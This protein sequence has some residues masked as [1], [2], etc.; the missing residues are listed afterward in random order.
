MTWQQLRDLDC[1][2][3]R[4]L[5]DGWKSYVDAM[6]DQTERLRTDVVD[7]HLAVEHYESDTAARVREQIGLTADRY[8]DDLS[9]YASTRIA[10]TL[11]E[12]ADAFEAEQGEIKELVPL[13]A[14]HDFEIEGDPA[15]YD[16]NL[17]G[18]LHRAIL[19][20]D[21]PQWLCDMVGI[22][23]PAGAFDL[24]RLKVLFNGV[25]LYGTAIGLAGQYQDWL[26][27][28]MSRT[29][30]ADDEAAAALTEMREHPTELPPRLGAAYDELV[31]DYREAVSEEVAAEAKAIAEGTSGM[32]PEQVNQW[33]DHLSDSERD[34]LVEDHPGWVG[35]VD[36]IPTGPRDTANRSLLDRE[37]DGLDA[38]IAD[39]ER[40]LAGTDPESDE[41]ETLTEAV[42]G[43]KD[44]RADLGRL[45]DRITDDD[46]GPAASSQTG[47]PFNLL[48]FDTEG[49]GRAVIA[50]GDPDGADN[51]NTYVPGT[52]NSLGTAGGLLSRAETMAFDAQR[53][54][55]GDDTATVMWL[56]YDTPDDLVQ[57][58]DAAFAR[59]GA[60]DLESFTKGLR[61]TA[62]GDP[63]NLT[64]TGHSYGT[65]MVG[66]AAAS[67][68]LPADNLVMIASPG[69]GVDTASALGADEDRVWA[70]VNRDDPIRYAPVHGMDPTEDGFGANTFTSDAPAESSEWWKFW[71]G[72]IADHSSYWDENN[73]ISRDN[74][75]YI[76]TGNEAGVR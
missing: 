7:G 37:I 21:P 17:S 61:A 54:G 6:L 13:I 59:E 16:V 76:V 49:G 53:L 4:A 66:T 32:S 52:G 34:A 12:A 40:L 3:I 74:Q 26:R 1:G 44:D 42:D 25:D 69:T 71:E 62:D 19:T 36:G 30:D 64:V 27:A 9:D 68:G 29:R 18:E 41:Y 70:T 31:G 51:V 23:K 60:R 63:A 46:G 22:A 38:Q 20:T 5:G 28:V 33:W 67:E 56:G 15:E 43:L 24:D 50:I 11:H 72:P 35:P 8:E 75:A 48:G 45:H 65:T 73:G 39:K 47:Q 58:T 57:A 14:A 2:A 10:T 55:G